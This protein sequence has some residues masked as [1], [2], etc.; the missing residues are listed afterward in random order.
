[1]W[2]ILNTDGSVTGCGNKAATSGLLRDEFG[3]CHSAFT[4][5]LGTCSITRPE[6]QGL[7]TGLR[8]A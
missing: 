1:G 7:L 2:I 5:N 3:R 4:T 8:Q 6:M